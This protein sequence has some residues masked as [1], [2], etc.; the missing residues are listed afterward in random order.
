M[1][2]A[3]QHTVCNQWLEQDHI[4]ERLNAV[5]YAFPVL[6]RVPQSVQGRERS[7]SNG[8]T[9]RIRQKVFTLRARVVKCHIFF[10]LTSLL[11][12]HHPG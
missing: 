6:M 9:M 11:T 5:P 12:M 8:G 7:L 3:R 1:A 2:L 10:P 4:P